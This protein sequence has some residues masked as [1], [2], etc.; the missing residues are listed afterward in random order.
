M[1]DLH[2]VAKGWAQEG[3]VKVQIS[4]LLNT[5]VIDSASWGHPHEQL[6][7]VCTRKEDPQTQ[8]S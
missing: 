8:Y 2:L 6:H 5:T 1:T 7:H 3:N 4:G